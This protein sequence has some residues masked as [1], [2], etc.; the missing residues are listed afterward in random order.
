MNSWRYP[1]AMALS[2]LLGIALADLAFSQAP[3][4]NSA[5]RIT[6]RATPTAIAITGS[7]FDSSTSV[8]SLSSSLAITDQLVVSDTSL[9]CVAIGT[10]TGFIDVV[11]KNRLGAV[12]IH[13]AIYCYAREGELLP[14]LVFFLQDLL[15]T[16]SDPKQRLFLSE[17]IDHL[18]LGI[19][20]LFQGNP[21]PAANQVAAAGA[22]IEAVSDALAEATA[23]IRAIL[24]SFLVTLA[25]NDEPKKGQQK[26]G[27]K[28]P[29][30]KKPALEVVLP[31]GKLLTGDGQRGNPGDILFRQFLDSLR[32][33]LGSD[34]FSAIQSQL[35][36]LGVSDTFRVQ[37]ELADRATM[38]ALL[39]RDLSKDAAD[40]FVKDLEA[41]EAQGFFPGGVTY[42]VPGIPP[43]IKVIIVQ[44]ILIRLLGTPAIM[45]LLIHEFLHVKLRAIDMENLARR[46]DKKPEITAPF[47]DHSAGFIREE[48]RLFGLFFVH[49]ILPTFTDR[50][51]LAQATDFFRQLTRVFGRDKAKAML[52]ALIGVLQDQGKDLAA[53]ILKALLQKFDDLIK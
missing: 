21:V 3:R 28:Q 43:V 9:T 24:L 27:D 30:E 13:S 51:V 53:D 6:K 37:V 52:R 15:P 44:E 20:H 41:A 25:N 47:S 5:I 33:F 39:E 2:M 49:R 18:N 8:T 26:Q 45:T 7:N 1:S 10:E 46:R 19:R 50:D 32:A 35:A 38:R 29:P 40:K 42:V 4:V 36:S 34:A 23:T 31:G 17:A 11:V 48:E 22:K 12:V 14:V 16:I